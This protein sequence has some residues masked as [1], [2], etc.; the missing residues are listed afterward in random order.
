MKKLPN[1]F[2][3]LMK[4]LL[5]NE[6][7]SFIK[8]YDERRYSGLRATHKKITREKLK[9]ILD[10]KVDDIP[11][12]ESGLYFQEEEKLGKHPYYH[13]GLYYIQEPSAM[14][15][16]EYLDIKDGMKILD[17][18]SAP[19][20]KSTQIAG[21]LNGTGLLVTNDIS[22]KRIKAVLK[23]IELYGVT[24]AVVVND[25]PEKIYNYF[26]EYFDA[27][28]LDVPCSGEGMFRKDDSLINSYEES[29]KQVPSLQSEILEYG[30][31]MLKPGGIIIYSTCTFNKEENEEKIIEFLNKNKDFSLVDI[32]KE[33]GFTQGYE[34]K[35]A[36]RLFP[37]NLKGEGHFI[38]KLMKKGKWQ[39]SE[40]KIIKKEPPKE[41]KEFEK[42][43]LNICL[44]GNFVSQDEKLFLEIEDFGNKKGIRLV[45]NG[46]FVGEIKNNKFLP[47][48]A[49][50]MSLNFG[51]VKNVIDFSKD[52][53]N[54]IKYLKGETIF[55]NSDKTGIIFISV[56]GYL[57]GYGK[58]NNGTIKNA[59]NKSWRIQ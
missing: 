24:N 2:L 9:T 55:V 28:L 7:E 56:D 16:V 21:K 42:Q 34:I 51:D 27:I 23:N 47:S 30:S 49:F 5:N 48:Q 52:D 8:T 36:A 53:S 33:Y 14:S 25:S 41:Y 29:M 4:G 44:E 12:C 43:Q 46:L 32:P 58:I 1:N 37:H 26:G 17:I 20:G 3:E 31:K 6:Y 22:E 35:E 50:I 11:W 45:R 10:F 40:K 57:L 19:G 54:L 13:A 39:A 15:P 18:C 38:C 59:Y